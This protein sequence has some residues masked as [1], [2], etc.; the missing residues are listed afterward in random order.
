MERRNAILRLYASGLTYQKI[1]DQ[2]GL[3]RQRIQQIV[4]PPIQV[5]V[6]LRKRANDCCER[7]GVQLTKYSGHVHHVRKDVTGTITDL[8]L[9]RYL[10]RGCHTV[11][12][13]DLGYMARPRVKRVKQT[14]PFFRMRPKSNIPNN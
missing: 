2:M 14:M 9:L 13:Y 6:L 3:T 11:E 12:N 8:N 10:C 5:I 1:A 4:R 7:C